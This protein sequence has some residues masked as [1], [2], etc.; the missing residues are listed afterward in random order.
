MSANKKCAFAFS[1]SE[2]L[3][4]IL[5]DLSCEATSIFYN[6]DA[7]SL[8]SDGE[9]NYLTMKAIKSVS[10]GLGV[11]EENKKGN[12]KKK[13]QLP[14]A[15]E[16]A[17]GTIAREGAEAKALLTEGEFSN[18]TE[19]CRSQLVKNGLNPQKS[20]ALSESLLLLKAGFWDD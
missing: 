2:V 13:Q 11:K 3:K 1:K 20:L 6:I 14:F 8:S 7:A 17:Y 15:G 12:G 5:K 10:D 18:F 16:D 4:T 19:E 9:Q